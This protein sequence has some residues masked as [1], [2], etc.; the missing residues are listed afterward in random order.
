MD[1]SWFHKKGPLDQHYQTE[2]SVGATDSSKGLVSH[3][4]SAAE[5]TH[6]GGYESTNGNDI[7]M[8]DFTLASN[9]GNGNVSNNAVRPVVEQ[10]FEEGSG[11]TSN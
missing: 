10:Q 5:L 9:N 11:F 6:A 4:T 3:E 8:G 2:P 1:P 7:D